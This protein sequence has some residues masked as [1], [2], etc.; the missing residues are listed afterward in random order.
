MNSAGPQ[1][2]QE[3]HVAALEEGRLTFQRCSDCGHAWL[4]ARHECPACWSTNHDRQEASGRATVVSWVVFHV[5]FDPRF[6]DRV[7]YNVALVDLDEGPRMT[8]NI[9]EI[10]EGEDIVGRRVALCFQ[11]DMGRKL[12]RFELT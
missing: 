4:P 7:P 2:P 3:A 11:E 8:T 6:K 9:I 12:P 5:A 1:T 10:P